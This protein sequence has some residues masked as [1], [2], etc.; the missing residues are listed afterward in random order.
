MPDRSPAIAAAVRAIG[1]ESDRDAVW[2][3]LGNGRLARVIAFAPGVHPFVRAVAALHA[4]RRH[5]AP[6]R[7]PRRTDR[8]AHVGGDRA[9]GMETRACT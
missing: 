7:N 9:C 3:A 2:F 1:G 8:A 4:P 6:A 5:G